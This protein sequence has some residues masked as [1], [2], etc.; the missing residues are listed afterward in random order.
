VL[1]V[2]LGQ[3]VRVSEYL[4]E[5][6]KTYRASARL[7]VA[8]DTFDAEGE[9][10]FEADP[11]SVDEAALRDALATLAGREE[12]TPPAYSALKVGGTP[13]HRLARAGKPVTLRPRRARIESIDLLS[14][15]PPSVEVE[16]RCGKGTYIRAL[17]NDLG[18][19]LGC[20]AHL[21]ALRRTAIGPFEAEDAVTVERLET[22]FAD[23]SWGELLL[24]LDYGLAHLPAVHLEM[25]AEKDVRHGIPLGA[26]LPAFERLA[27]VE[28]GSRS[29]AYAEDGSFVGILRYDGEAGLWRPQKVFISG[30]P[31]P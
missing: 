11:S 14:F 17:A 28:E 25:E 27:G 10:V 16:V 21:T 24:P 26:E 5:L 3:A 20:G 18:G 15:D 12:Q 1:L 29:R 2:C 6:P 7:G 13:A 31:T 19:L 4:M 22:A 23:G 8:T 9:T 30:Q